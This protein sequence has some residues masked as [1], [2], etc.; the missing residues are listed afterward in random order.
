MN[1]IETELIGNEISN[2][3]SYLRPVHVTKMEKVIMWSLFVLVIVG[4]A[5]ALYWAALHGAL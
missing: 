1:N 4:F 5:S 3:W 2:T